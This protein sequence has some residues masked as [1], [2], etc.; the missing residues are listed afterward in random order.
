MS[1]NA[2]ILL[3]FYVLLSLYSLQGNALDVIS[4]NTKHLGR[5]GFRTDLAI[6]LIED[7]DIITLQEVGISE[8]S[9]NSLK[10]LADNLNKKTGAKMC[11]G[12]S[13]IPTGS[14]ER[15]AYLWR[16]DSVAYIKVDGVS[17]MDCPDTAITIRLG[18]KHAKEIVREPAFGT[19]LDK[20]VNERFVLA[21]IHLVPS[22][23]SPQKEIPPLID[24]FKD[25]NEPTIIA[26]DF[27]LDSSHPSFQSVFDLAFK[28]VFLGIPTSLKM[29]KRLLNKPY[30]N[31]IYR[32]L[33]LTKAHVINLY[34]LLP[35]IDQQ[36]IYKDL[37]DHSPIAA[38]FSFNNKLSTH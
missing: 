30:D 18:V 23:K 21:S 36:I 32:K 12:L 17:I 35:K 37:S 15:Y 10:T 25:V 24:T 19:F 26:G 11:I 5:D 34:D 20:R 7:A 13:E 38:S 22:G 6:P 3:N 2:H 27:N 9:M 4:W 31:F 14:K 16:N 8:S 1:H 28:A 29:K 33:F